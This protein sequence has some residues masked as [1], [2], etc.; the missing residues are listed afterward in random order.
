MYWS[1][2]PVTQSPVWF[3][4]LCLPPEEDHKDHKDVHTGPQ[5]VTCVLLALKDK[6]SAAGSGRQSRAEMPGTLA[7][8]IAGF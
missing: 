6:D 4:C 2:C 5:G 1:F 3:R 7:C 8:Q